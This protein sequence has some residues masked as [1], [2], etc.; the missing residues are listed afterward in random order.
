MNLRRRY[1]ILSFSIGFISLV[2]EIYSTRALFFFI[3]GSNQA[4]TITI[5]AFLAGL[6]FSGLLFS[7]LSKTD[8]PERSLKIIWYMQIASAVYS[9][10]LLKNYGLIPNL[11]DKS[12]TGI[13]YIWFAST[14]KYILLW[15]Y[16]FVPAFFI[17]G[18]FPLINGLYLKDLNSGAKDTGMVY[19]WDTCGAIFGALLTGFVFLPQLGF[20]LTATL[21]AIL[22]L[23]VALSLRIP[24]VYK[25]IAGIGLFI[26][27]ILSYAEIAVF[28]SSI[29]VDL[30]QQSKSSSN[31]IRRDDLKDRFGTILFQKDSPFGLIT[32][33]QGMFGLHDDNEGLFINY[34]SM[35]MSKSHSSESDVGSMTTQ[36]L[37]VKS[38]VLVIGLGCGFTTDA[39]VQ[40][41][42]VEH[43]DIVEINPIIVEAA[44]KFFAQYNNDVTH[45]SKVTLYVQDGAEFLRQGIDNQYDAIVVNIEEPSIIYSS[46]LYTAEYFA[47]AKRR[48]KPNGILSFWAENGTPE[49]GKILFNT[50]KSVFKNAE[51]RLP[52]NNTF[53]IYFASDKKY[54]FSSGMTTLE[55]AI[56]DR[57]LASP[58][59]DINTID[60]HKL[61]KNFNIN[62]FANL[63]KD[64][65]EPLVGN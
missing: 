31:F 7:S 22:N 32:I 19:F 61:E 65:V 42:N 13:T 16:M 8:Q 1:L 12:V 64:Y 45:S 25:I 55:K 62:D 35:C 46:P 4:V 44:E 51:F 43:V 60:N 24:S 28:I 3:P 30:Q 21:A 36:A 33:G 48:L 18:S 17:G 49:Y 29:K 37:P 10:L 26:I 54:D 34:R 2:Y 63:P 40:D 41:K 53:F 50:L 15:I 38:R 58:T 5:S 57:I 52:G 11:I 14:A 56:S 47:I 20:L 6:A 23:S 59:T 39:V 27:L 9:I